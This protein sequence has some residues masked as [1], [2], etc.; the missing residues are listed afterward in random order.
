[1]R[2]CS[3]CGVSKEDSMFYASKGR[4]E[5][6]CKS[7]RM[8]YFLSPERRER[9]RELDSNY[10][11]KIRGTPT[12]RRKASAHD[13]VAYAIRVGKI[14]REPCRECGRVDSKGHHPDYAKPL[15]VIWLCPVHHA[16]AHQQV[17]VV[18]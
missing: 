8:S 9:K 1:M 13:K 14:R 15:E 7:C 4:I 3:E 12:Y 16:A 5:R 18:V 6:R 2:V 17:M 11:R 10:R